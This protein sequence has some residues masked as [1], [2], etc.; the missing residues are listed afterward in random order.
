VAS[1]R[2]VVELCCDAHEVA[3]LPHAALD[4]VAH[5]KFL[6]DLLQ[7]NGLLNGSTAIA[8]R[9]GSGKA[10]RGWLSFGGASAG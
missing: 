5:A 3:V 8:G 4:D 2:R 10:E 9:S 6:G 7:V 1:C